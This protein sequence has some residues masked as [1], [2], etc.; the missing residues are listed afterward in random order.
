MT[1]SIECA[2]MLA[3]AAFTSLCAGPMSDA[4]VLFLGIGG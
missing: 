3:A 1:T 2:M 4:L